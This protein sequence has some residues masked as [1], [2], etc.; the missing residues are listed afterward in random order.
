M[1]IEVG[2]LKAK[3]VI[4]K[5]GRMIGSLIGADIDPEDWT[6]ATV[7]I[8]VEKDLVEPRGLERSSA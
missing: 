7:R 1:D 4:T 6:V 8:E 2:C 3:N 5:G